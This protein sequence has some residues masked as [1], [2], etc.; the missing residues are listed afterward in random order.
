LRQQGF[1]VGSKNPSEIAC[2]QVQAVLEEQI[3][4]KSRKIPQ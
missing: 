2:R 1:V 4:V 3:F